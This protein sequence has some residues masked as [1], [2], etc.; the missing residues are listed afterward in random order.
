MSVAMKPQRGAV[1]E[2]KS[3]LKWRQVVLMARVFARDKGGG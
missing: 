2:E 1:R 3:G